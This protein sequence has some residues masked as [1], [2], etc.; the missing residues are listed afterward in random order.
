MNG[1]ALVVGII[2]AMIVLPMPADAIIVVDMVVMDV[3]F[4]AVGGKILLGCENGLQMGADQR[5]DPGDL[6]RKKQPQQP[7][8]HSTHVKQ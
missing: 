7:G 3:L 5:N 1:A 2:C 4:S 6:G 8:T